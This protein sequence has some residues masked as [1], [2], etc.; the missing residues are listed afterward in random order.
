MVPMCTVFVAVASKLAGLICVTA[1]GPVYV[2]NV[3]VRVYV[4]VIKVE[5]EIKSSAYLWACVQ[6]FE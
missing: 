4:C 5:H 6:N 2:R 3:Y 1:M